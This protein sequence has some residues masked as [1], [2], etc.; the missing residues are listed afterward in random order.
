MKTANILGKMRN[1]TEIG[2]RPDSPNKSLGLDTPGKN[3]TSLVTLEEVKMSPKNGAGANKEGPGT[4]TSNE[5]NSI[6]KNMKV[7][8]MNKQGTFK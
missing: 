1:S 6:V 8:V 7:S 4:K 2:S 5:E 3:K